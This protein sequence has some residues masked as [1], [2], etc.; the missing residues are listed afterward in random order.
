MTLSALG[1]RYAHALADVVM[2]PGA[3]TG[4]ETAAAQLREFEAALKLSPDLQNALSSPAVPPARKRAV[5][6]KIGQMLAIAPIVRNFLFVLIDHRRIGLL[7]EIAQEF[8][9][10]VDERLGFAQAKVTSARELNEPQRHLLN[11]E[12]E[13]LTGKKIKI[14][15][16]VDRALIGGVIAKVGSTVYDGSV[17]G[18]LNALGRRLGVEAH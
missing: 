14:R 3:A 4:A 13:R 5:V 17:R 9:V 6:A 11:G 8:Q 1:N 15:F 12:L 18:Q 2:E 10:I 16:E 7:A